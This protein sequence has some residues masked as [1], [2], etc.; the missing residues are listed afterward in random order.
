M[1][2][3]FFGHSAHPLYGVYH[4]P[5]VAK[6]GSVH[7][8][9]LCYPFGQEYMRAHRAYR[10]LASQL[11]KK[12]YHVMRFDYRGTGDSYGDLNDVVFSDWLDDVEVAAE[13]LKDMTSA[14]E[15]SIVGLRLGALVAATAAQKIP[16]LSGL[17][18]W[19]PIISGSA[20]Q[21]EL[22]DEMPE[23]GSSLSNFVDESGDIHFNGFSL[24]KDFLQNATSY[25]LLK[26]FDGEVKL[27]QRVLQIVSHETPEFTDLASR[28]NIGDSF[29]YAYTPAPGDWNF[30]DNWGGI[31]LPQPVIQGIVDW[32]K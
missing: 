29:E 14:S 20:Y 27:A 1:N 4:P 11:A 28:P 15:M 10:Q 16:D 17:I 5:Q 21:Q 2:P 22:V 6:R 7:A 31:L 12:G 24:H 8:V 32:F 9:L 25:D 23:Q 30:V 26:Q 19:D 3:F 13:E 18:L